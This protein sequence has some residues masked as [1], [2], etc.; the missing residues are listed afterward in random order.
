MLIHAVT[1]R[2]L[3]ASMLPADVGCIVDNCDTVCAIGE[4][5]LYGKPLLSRVVTVSGDGISRPGRS[6]AR[7]ASSALSNFFLHGLLQSK[8]VELDQAYRQLRDSYMM[9]N[10]RH[11]QC[12]IHDNP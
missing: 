1:G 8:N 12:V 7:Q 10:S 4:A 6:A 9:A 2:K 3:N 11:Y 5:V